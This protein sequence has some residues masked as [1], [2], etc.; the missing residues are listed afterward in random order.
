MKKALVS[1]VIIVMS[2]QLAAQSPTYRQ[3]VA[4]GI[5]VVKILKKTSKAAV[6]PMIYG[7]MLEDC[8]DNVVY[9]GVV[10]NAGEENPK[11]IELLRPLNIPVM[12]WPAG[13]AIYD[14][15]WRRGIGPK[16]KRT[17]IHEKVWGG[18]EYYTFGTDEFLSWCKKIGTEPY[19]NICMGNSA[20]RDVTLDDA[21]DWVEYVNGAST[22]R[23]GALRAANGHAEPYGVRL[24]CLGNENYLRAIIHKEETA[25]QYS[26]MLVAWSKRLKAIDK[27]LSLLGVGHVSTWNKTVINRVGDELD[28][29]TLHYY[30]TSQVKDGELLKP[31]KTLF[32]SARV[33]ENL[34]V[35]IPLLKSY[36]EKSGR[37]KNPLRF[38]IDE[39]NNRHKVWG[40][41]RY[42]FTRKDDRRMYD[43]ACTATM[44]NVFLRNSPHVAMANYI[45]P[46]NGHGL[47]KTVGE[48]DA[49]KS[50][51][52]HVFD[53][54][55]RY[56]AGSTL[57]IDVSGPGKNGIRLSETNV[58]GDNEKSVDDM[59]CNLCYIDCAAT[60]ADK[61]KTICVALVNR[62]YTE[63]QT[64]S[65]QLPGRYKAAE[66]WAVEADDVKAANSREERD[67]VKAERI[68]VVG[69]QV[70]IKPCGLII[71]K[72]TKQ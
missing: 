43:V 45:F 40:G 49:Y 13:T 44:L 37:K 55:R 39:W 24:W 62:S 56:M 67:K 32:A 4:D 42:S 18:T 16:E 46:V 20:V 15:D 48:C 59:V 6:N 29:L 8:N 21:V 72:F 23:M 69:H 9:G 25:E 17:P 36:N 60:S 47:L 71:I 22:T 41:D 28:Y 58:E 57:S 68:D 30:L 3:S 10:N 11:V 7:Q 64:V 65:L 5:T 33:E 31:E 14:Y 38:S 66:A 63:Q 34:K 61:G 27:N 12:R 53:L 1:C 19:I 52:Y 70:T 26:D 51:S 54:Y 35:N 2:L 50:A